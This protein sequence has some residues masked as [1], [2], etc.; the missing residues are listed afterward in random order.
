MAETVVLET[1]A[2]AGHANLVT[3][4]RVTSAT[5]GLE[6]LVTAGR[7]ASAIVGRV[8]TS[9]TQGRDRR[10][11]ATIRRVGACVASFSWR[12]CSAGTRWLPGSCHVTLP[13][14]GFSEAR[15]AAC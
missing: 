11:R 2:T 5:V 1:S 13:A 6:T 15:F 12:E 9:A 4:G 14:S 3:A 7:A 8:R 10:P